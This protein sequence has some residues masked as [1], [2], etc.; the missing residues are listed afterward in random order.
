MNWKKNF[1]EGKELVLSTSSKS[2]NPNSNIVISLGFVNDKLLVANCQMDTTIK[3]LKENP[4]ISVVGS[5]FR[6]RGDIEIFDSGEVFDKGVEIVVSQDK[7]LK[8]RD[9]ISINVKDVFDLEN[10][11]KII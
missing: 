3:N 4:K 2:G 6:I 9:I 8:V 1:E 5:Y 10:S 11:E 7:S